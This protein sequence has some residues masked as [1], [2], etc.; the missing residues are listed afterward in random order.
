MRLGLHRPASVM[1]A[2]ALVA[3]GCQSAGD[4]R[5]AIG[6]GEAGGAGVQ[7]SIAPA[8]KD[9]RP[10]LPI[11]VRAAGG[12]IQN[13]WVT[14]RG[15]QVEGV[16]S[17]DGTTWRSRWPLSPATRHR[18]I[19]TAADRRGKAVTRSRSFTT[20][21]P[22]QTI[23]PRVE[24]PFD[25]ER[26]G[27]GMPIILG[28]DRPV[29][30]RD[31]VAKALE[32]RSAEPV[33]GAWRWTG[34]Q[35]VA[36]R[37]RSYWRPGQRVNLIAHL[38]GVR[39]AKDVYGAHDLKAGFTVGDSMISTVNTRTYTM[40][41]KRAGKVIRK[42]PIS[43]GRATKRA[44]TTTSGVHLIMSKEYKVVADSATVGIPKGDPDYYRLDLYWALRI[45]NSGEYVHSAPWSVAD[46]GRRNVSHGCVNAG[47]K[48]AKWFYQQ[49]QRGDIV[50]VTGTDR[51]LEWNNGWG[52]W[53][54]PWQKWSK[55]SPPPAT[56]TPARPPTG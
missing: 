7:I 43:A 42:V 5:A 23:N 22:R 48:N 1:F 46:Q 14:A 27:V 44:Y 50:I 19:A 37:P 15:R 39:A 55:G 28:F 35:Q 52:F 3:A 9:V 32:V 4:E 30:N 29:F 34:P 54:L 40:T 56:T 26:V 47:P 11:T 49:A 18:V 45:S 33:T 17:P 25:G 38:K 21:T 12:R 20:L 36:F 51:E 6:S 24:A 2:A 13:V 8:G 16:L 41:V 31:Q 53:Q 10:D